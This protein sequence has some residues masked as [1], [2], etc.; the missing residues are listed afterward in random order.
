MRLRQTLPLPNES[1]RAVRA[2]TLQKGWSRKS[3]QMLEA[4]GELAGEKRAEAAQ[5]AVMGLR[6][7]LVKCAPYRTS[8]SAEN[9][10]KRTNSRGLEVEQK[11]KPQ[12]AT[13]SG[14]LS[15]SM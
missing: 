14:V 12:L 11:K 4:K 9:G 5:A 13:A 7:T 2:T 6:A 8:W 10:A 1:V 15:V 3:T